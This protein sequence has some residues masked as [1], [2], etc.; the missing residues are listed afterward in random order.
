MRSASRLFNCC[1]M[2]LMGVVMAVAQVALS[3]LPN[4]ELVSFLTILFT[5]VFRKRVLGALPVFLLLEGL[6][7]GFGNWWLMYLYIW[8]LLSL[9]AWLFRW[10]KRPWQWALFSGV[11]GL[12]FGT[13]CALVYLPLGASVTV[14]WI[15]SG[16]WFDLLHA[17]GNFI[18]MLVL[19]I[20]VRR[21]LEALYVQLPEH[22]SQL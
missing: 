7:Y 9:L 10:V 13:L 15:L 16:L 19:Y 2:A 4:I 8:P 21:A 11:Y 6:L 12:L 5:L 1:L 18:V 17:G 20:P 3:F 22:V 14:A